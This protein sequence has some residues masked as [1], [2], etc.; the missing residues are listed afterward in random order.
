MIYERKIV[1]RAIGVF[2]QKMTD[3]CEDFDFS[4]LS[5]ELGEQM[6]AH[7]SEAMAASAAEGLKA[8][9]ESYD[10]DRDIIME[11]DRLLR[12]K[13]K[14]SK[15]FLTCFGEVTI[16]RCLYQHDRGGPAF[17]PLDAAWGMQGQ[18]GTIGVREAVSFASGHCTPQEVHELLSKCS[19]FRP[20]TTAIK[21]IIDGVGSIMEENRAEMMQEVRAPEKIPSEAKVM[22]TSF[23]GANVLMRL[24]GS[25]NR[26]PA[27]RPQINEPSDSSVQSAYRNA[28][29]GSISLYG[30]DESSH[31]PR[32]LCSRYTARMPQDRAIEFK[33]GLEDDVDHLLKDANTMGL[34]KVLLLDGSRALWT[35]AQGNPLYKG[36]EMVIDFFHVVDHLSK[37]SE[38]IFG[39][40]SRKG[41]AWF[42]KWRH[43]LL[44]SPEGAAGV[45]RSIEYYSSQTK[46]SASRRKDLNAEI[47]FFRRN[48]DRMN[49][50]SLRERR[51][52]IGSGPV[53]AACKS[54][55]KNRL[56][57]SG[58]RWS[59]SGGQKILTF[60]T[61]IKS[62]R[63]DR[64]WEQYKKFA[65]AA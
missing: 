42:G 31:E 24:P 13:G 32:R 27:E 47:T 60:R 62:Q 45:L 8:Y 65:Q 4:H 6:C 54:I 46:L 52:P 50:A 53:E 25:R 20:S 17:A 1:D 2:K 28:M 41:K 63:W 43:K 5:A 9:V 35:Y 51:I 3:L 59:H 7:L 29:V 22:V 40:S 23:D 26:R 18:Y 36:F 21:H 10:I 38:A 57:R 39:K 19:L 48:K 16:E 37:I 12:N 64:A 56:C 34:H 58:M 14:V 61:L 15:A 33:Q 30:M 49:Y 55:V 11:D 44:T